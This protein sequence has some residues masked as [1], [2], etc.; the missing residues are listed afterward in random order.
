MKTL[1]LIPF[2]LLVPLILGRGA[3]TISDLITKDRSSF[4]ESFAL[5]YLLN[6][7]I[8]GAAHILTVFRG[9]P[10]ADAVRIYAILLIVFASIGYF[11]VLFVRLRRG[12]KSVPEKPAQKNPSKNTAAE[13]VSGKGGAASA[14][15]GPASRLF[16]PA[17]FCV[18]ILICLHLI[19]LFL[20]GTLSVFS[21]PTAEMTASL[22]GDQAPF[23]RSFL[24]GLPY[25][26]GL[27]SRIR[28]LSLPTY[29]AILCRVFDVSPDL[30]LFRILPFF[31]Y[32][33]ALAALHAPA[34]ALFPEKEKRPERL[35]FFTAALLLLTG[36]G[37]SAS[38]EAFGSLRCAWSASFLLC[39]VL[40][41]FLVSALSRKN[42]LTA[43]V[44]VAA[45]AVL[46]WTWF[47]AGSCALIYGG[48]VLL[49]LASRLLN[50][51]GAAKAPSRKGGSR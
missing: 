14:K 43:L 33:V 50:R 10:L 25:Q 48:Y 30:L 38:P 3:L 34:R 32:A 42:F 46:L 47:G 4:S 24:T 2:L 20:P 51:R 19:L 35:I 5:G 28:L 6:L 7:C 44:P 23:S 9:K 12:L 36:T 15:G 41:P 11:S 40:I 39:M 16:L 18:G 29:Y 37:F 21:D 13:S 45:E 1:L 49:I 27:P 8:A 31:H 26:N 17:A 22:L